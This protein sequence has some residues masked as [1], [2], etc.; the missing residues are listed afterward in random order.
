MRVKRHTL[1]NA[2]QVAIELYK[3]SAKVDARFADQFN[4]QAEEIKRIIAEIEQNDVIQ[5]ED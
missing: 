2:L 5:L 4:R 1:T 3:T